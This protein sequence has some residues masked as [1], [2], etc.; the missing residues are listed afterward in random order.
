M[1]K[2]DRKASLAAGK[3]IKC[4]SRPI[5]A[6]SKSLCNECLAK[7]KERNRNRK[8]K[9]R[10]EGICTKCLG[11]LAEP[12]RKFCSDCIKASAAAL[13]KKHKA[14]ICSR[15]SKPAVLGLKHCEECRN[16]HLMKNKTWQL[17]RREAVISHYSS[18]TNV[19][20]CCAEDEFD[21]LTIDH[22]YGGGN[23]HRREAKI[24]NGK[25]YQ[26][27]IK[28]NFPDGFQVLCWNCNCGRAKHKG[29]CPH[30][31]KNV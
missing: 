11:R 2:Y 7:L 21:F 9:C 17:R 27:L 15:C 19:C 31:L 28:N 12:N 23:K 22:I 4:Q 26:W 5:A 6:R 1:S 10:A 8:T 30:K 13:A 16:E 24:G 3:C 14:G 29:I 20:A 18:G 25:T